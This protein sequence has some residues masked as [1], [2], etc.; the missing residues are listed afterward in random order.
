[1]LMLVTHDAQDAQA[2][3]DMVVVV[4]RGRVLQT[5]SPEEV[6]RAPRTP[7]IAERV[8]RRTRWPGVVTSLGAVSPR[9]RLVTVEVLRLILHALMPPER[10]VRAGQRVEAGISPDEVVVARAGME[11]AIEA[12]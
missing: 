12:Q 2:L 5:G 4:D 3:A 1:P 8:G 11:P 10:K 7:R 6:F 9:G